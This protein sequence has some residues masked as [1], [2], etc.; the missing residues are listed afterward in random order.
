MPTPS[1]VAGEEIEQLAANTRA[2]PAIGRP[3]CESPC[4]CR[5]IQPGE[6][7]LVGLLDDHAADQIG[8]PRNIA[9][10]A[11]G[12]RPSTMVVIAAGWRKVAVPI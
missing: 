6:I 7:R 4:S 10:Q 1:P 3:G 9:V 8:D 2:S 5:R 11:K 12:L